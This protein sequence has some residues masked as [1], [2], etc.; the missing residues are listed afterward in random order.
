[1]IIH[2]LRHGIA[3]ERTD[4]D[5]PEDSRR[6]L[7]KRGRKRTK[8]VVRGLARVGVT[9][10][11]VLTSPYLRA[12]QTADIAIAELGLRKNAR[13]TES[14]MWNAGPDLLYEELKRL[15]STASVLCTGHA[16][17]LDLFIAHLVGTP[18]PFTELKKAGCATLSCTFTEPG[19]GILLS[20]YPP[21][22]MRQL[23]EQ[24]Q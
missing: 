22:P 20:L 2:L 9:A 21:R 12:Q 18:L 8:A 3:I 17:H 7:T 16:P 10:D 23:A 14:L 6:F 4:P 11:L 15:S 13:V 19:D 5:C 1:M 24:A